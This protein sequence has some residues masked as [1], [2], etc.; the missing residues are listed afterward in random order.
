MDFTPPPIPLPLLVFRADAVLENIGPF[1]AAPLS[2]YFFGAQ[3]SRLI[4]DAFRQH[5]SPSFREGQDIR[6]HGKKDYQTDS[7]MT[8]YLQTFLSKVGLSIRSHSIG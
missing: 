5:Y 7:V 6:F 4:S 2:V 1:C 8:K 3:N